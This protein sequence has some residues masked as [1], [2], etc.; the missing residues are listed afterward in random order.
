[1]SK[2]N[3]MEVIGIPSSSEV[4]LIV[5]AIEKETFFGV[6]C[7]LGSFIDDFILLIDELPTQCRISIVGYFN[8]E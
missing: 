1:M 7:M 4:L 6:Y 5:L 8:F 2:V 3:I